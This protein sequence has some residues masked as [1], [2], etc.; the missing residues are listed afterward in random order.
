MS[1]TVKKVSA[2]ARV[3]DAVLCV[4]FA[5]MAFKAE[6]TEWRAFWGVCSAFC[7]FT[8]ATGPLDRLP[9]LIQRLVGVRKG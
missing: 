6:G 8:A 2:G 1:T 4:V 7:A 5:Y 3:L 9:A